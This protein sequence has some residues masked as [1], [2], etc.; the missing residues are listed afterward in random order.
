MSALSAAVLDFL[1]VDGWP[2]VEADPGEPV[3]LSFKGA[4]G[5]WTCLVTMDDESSQVAF[6]SL[7]PIVV[8]GPSIVAAAELLHR[9]NAG[10][11]LGCFELEYDTGNVRYRT[12]AAWAGVAVDAALLRPL[13]YVNVS[14]MDR[15]LPALATVAFGGTKPTDALDLVASQP[16]LVVADDLGAPV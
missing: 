10:L 8:P 5:A 14:M 3:R 4:S 11:H 13:L 12:G 16:D 1:R 7:C 9:I 2:F 15:Y 6:Y